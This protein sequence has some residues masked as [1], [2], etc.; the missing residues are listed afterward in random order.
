[1]NQID[2]SYVLTPFLT[3]FLV[4]CLKF[5]ISAIKSKSFNLNLIGYGGMPSNHAAIVSSTATLIAC[6]DGISSPILGL[7]VM[8]AFIVLMDAFSLRRQIGKQAVQLNNILAEMGQKKIV[9]ER[10]GHS[11]LEILIGI[12]VGMAI[13]LFIAFSPLKLNL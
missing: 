7:A 5:F 1:M 9:R 3:W 6:T 11:F 12:F 10:I 8:F 2:L 4:G 13:G